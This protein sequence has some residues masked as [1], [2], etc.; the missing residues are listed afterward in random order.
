MVVLELNDFLVFRPVGE[1][2]GLYGCHELSQ[3][4]LFG[5]RFRSAD[6]ADFGHRPSIRHEP[7]S[8]VDAGLA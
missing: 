1:A 3:T 5:G 6:R 7:V 4:F 2:C 8:S